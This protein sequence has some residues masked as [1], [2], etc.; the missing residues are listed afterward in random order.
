TE[1]ARAIFGL[2][3]VDR[4]EIRLRDRPV[5]IREPREA[6]DLGIAYLP[7]DRR[8]HGV[9]LEMSISANI[10]LASLKRLSR[11]AS[12]DFER[13]REMATEYVQS[14]AIKTPSILNKG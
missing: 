12:Y 11:H 10:T 2:D 13:E 1:L 6:I 8:R 5:T 9:V 14:F 3:Q 4:G 7:E